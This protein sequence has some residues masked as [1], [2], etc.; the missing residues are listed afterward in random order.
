MMLQKQATAEW[1]DLFRQEASQIKS[2][3]LKAMKMKVWLGPVEDPKL[4]RAVREV[5][6]KDFRL[7]VDANH[8]YTLNDA[9]YVGRGL[10]EL[11]IFW[12]EEPV[13]PE[14]YNGYRELKQKINTNIAGG[15]AEFTK[16]GW[17]E[18]IKNKCVD[19]AQ[20]EVCGLGGINE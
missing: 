3:N 10:D 8:A 17:N 11:D 2:K 15:E 12:F 14:D 6:G 13:A 16:Y 7:M 20:P 4:V 1:I 19:M 5:V 9:L 18:L